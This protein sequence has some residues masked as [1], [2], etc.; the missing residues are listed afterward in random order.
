MEKYGGEN[1]Q[2]ELSDQND[3]RFLTNWFLTQLLLML[4]GMAVFKYS[5]GNQ[6]HL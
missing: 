6:N 1:K 3:L 2:W 5:F 4:E